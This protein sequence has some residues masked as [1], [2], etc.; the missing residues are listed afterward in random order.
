MKM[1]TVSALALAMAGVF[2]VAYAADEPSLSPEAKAASA[3]L[4]FE[5]CAGCHGILRKG[6]TGK[7]LEPAN[8][9]KLGH[10]R[11]EKIISYGTEGGMVNF[12]D[13][14]TKEEI[15]NM[16]T[17]IQLTPDTPPEWGMKDMMNSWKLVIKPEDRPKKPMSKVNLKNVFSVTLRDTGEVALIDGD[18]KQIWGIVKTGYAVHISRVSKSGRYV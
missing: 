1:F 7:N 12:D 9:I 14:L 4:Y 13:I 17:Y 6:A 3:K 18:T 10:N 15:S 16:A 8:S 2:N 11:L 5:R